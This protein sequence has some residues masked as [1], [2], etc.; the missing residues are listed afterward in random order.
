[1]LNLKIFCMC[2]DNS[3]LETVKKLN[4]IPVGLKNKNFSDEWILDNTLANISEKNPFYGEYTFYYWYWK[5]M[6]KNK[7]NDEW[8]G[9]CSYR[10]L[11]GESKDVQNRNS[12][13]SLIKS[14]PQEWKGY[15]AIIGEPIKLNKPKISKILKYGK[16]SFLRNFREAFKAE[17]S[18]R[19]HFDMFHG[20][21]F[22]DKAIELL[23]EK[24]KQDFNKYV[25]NND[26]F[27]QGNMFIS[28]SS[29]VINSYFTEV[30]DWLEKC[31][32][33]FGFN[34]NG[35]GKIRMYTFLAERFLP[36]WFKKYTKSLEWP[37]IYCDINKK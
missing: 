35:Y 10:E 25:R 2:L 13:K 15:D 1:M 24:D 4:Y 8:I 36:Y 30:F 7:Q 28:N 3:Y 11:W 20:N 17:F 23:P 14:L 27:N 21:G 16:I 12:I 19:F 32:S 5:N 31:E 33:V 22:L 34:L 37:V 9:F 26:S 6:L 29:E 18:I